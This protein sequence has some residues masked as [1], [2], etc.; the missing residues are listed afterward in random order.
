MMKLRTRRALALAGSAAALSV[1]LSGCSALN[2]FFGDGAGDAARDEKTGQVTES[3]NIGI[4]SLKVGDCMLSSPTGLLE[5]I[6]VV[7]CDEPHD[8]EVFHEFRLEDTEYS[9][10]AIDASSEACYTEAFADFTGIGYE[11][12]ALNVYPINPSEESWDEVEDHL[13]QCVIFD[14]AG[15]VTGSL[16]G[17]AR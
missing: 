14:P 10:E 7:P 2:G 5:D 13:I 16:K 4:F 12:S 8:E 15:P 1:A 3:A 9:A 6:D 11:A 17:S